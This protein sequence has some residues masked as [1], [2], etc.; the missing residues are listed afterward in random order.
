MCGIVGIVSNDLINPD[1]IDSLINSIKHRGPDDNGYFTSDNSFIAN[2]RLS[3]IDIESG[4]QP[5]I[6]EDN[7]IGLVQ[8][9]EIYNYVELKNELLDLGYSFK[10]NS[11][12]E[13]LLVCYI[14]YGEKFVCKLN[15]MFSIAILDKNINKLLLYRDRLGV[16]PLYTYIQDDLIMFSSEIKSFLKHEKFKK[17]LN[18]QSIHNYFIFN[19]I[20]IPE[21]IFESVRHVLP[22]HFLK[23]DLNNTFF[24]EDYKYWELENCAEDFL[25]S[26]DEYLKEI[27]SLL[28]D[29]T[30]IRMR[31]DV[32]VGAF[33]SGGLDSSLVCAY[34]KS[35][36]NSSFETFTIGFEEKEFDETKYAKYITEKFGL[37]F[38]LRILKSDIID[39]WRVTTWHN[40]QPHGDISFIPTYIVSNFASQTHKLVLTGDGGDEL[41]AGYNKY[42]SL[43][44]FKAN[45]KE[46]FDSISL[47]VENEDIN[48][49]YTNDF[50]A[51]VDLGGAFKLYSDIMNRASFKDNINK[52]LYFDTIQL[53]PGNNLV[54]PDKMGMANS[55]EARSPFL[56]YRFFELLMR[57]PGERKINNGE[58]K[59]ILKK[60]ALRYFGED[61][62]YRDKQMFTVPIGEWFKNKLSGFLIE[63]LTDERFIS[64]NILNQ[65]SIV[66]MI[67]TH[68]SGKK[69]YTRELRAI[70]NLELWFREFID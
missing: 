35:I 38:N 1:C 33:L 29:A 17:R 2:T 23:I 25:V 3:I 8:N 32:P 62:V 16:K 41:F 58:T 49:L 12:T 66:E 14:A 43:D 22:G 21:T 52:A 27:D 42:F 5:F 55:L 30:K 7:S 68:I 24:V 46:Y 19:Y 50:K 67:E 44:K 63:T 39:L 65:S 37:V 40:D 54:K 45:S 51:Q 56:D 6:N 13:V 48:N 61:H 69:N 34:M 59:H 53:L 31:S 10:T 20:P 60:L 9:G 64:R 36:G 26:D 57:I 18:Y 4:H 70:V 15:G 28:L 47:F 11:D